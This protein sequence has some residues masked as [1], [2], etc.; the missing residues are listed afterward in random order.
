MGYM[1]PHNCQAQVQ[2]W[3]EQAQLAL[4]THGLGAI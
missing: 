3:P 1:V 4:T 2:P